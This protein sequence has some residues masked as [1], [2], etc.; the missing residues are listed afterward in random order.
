MNANMHS[1]MGGHRRQRKHR[2]HR[3]HKMKPKMNAAPTNKNQ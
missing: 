1:T 2:R 3:R